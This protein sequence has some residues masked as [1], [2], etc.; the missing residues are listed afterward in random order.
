MEVI[1]I[2]T[3]D[4]IFILDKND[5]T[6][7]SISIKN[8]TPQLKD[9]FSR[10]I[11]DMGV[12]YEFLSGVLVQIFDSENGGCEMF[13]SKIPDSSRYK[14]SD[15]LEGKKHIYIFKSLGDLLSA[16]RML[17]HKS[18]EGAA[19]CDRR[20]GCY[21]LI[22]DEECRY[23]GEFNSEKCKDFVLEHLTEHCTLISRSAV[24]HLAPL[25]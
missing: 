2:G 6:K 10:L 4:L 21:F 11:A 14:D 8:D 19:F 12:G 5:M 3:T 23:L 25:A 16:C 17:L 24:A 9:G 13:V 22:L 20:R 1:E 15:K 7:Y 18:V